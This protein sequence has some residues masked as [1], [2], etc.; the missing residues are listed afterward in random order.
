MF[1]AVFQL[2]HVEH[3]NTAKS[4][5][6]FFFVINIFRLVGV[7]FGVVLTLVVI[8]KLWEGCQSSE[9]NVNTC[10]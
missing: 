10:D 9:S 7:V 3:H 2:L 4:V 5:V 8:K 6:L 1:T